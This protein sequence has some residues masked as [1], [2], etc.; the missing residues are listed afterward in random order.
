MRQGP[1]DRFPGRVGPPSIS[2]RNGR[3]GHAWLPP[4][5]PLGRVTCCCLKAIGLLGCVAV[6]L[7]AKVT[8]TGDTYLEEWLLPWGGMGNFLQEPSTFQCFDLEPS[9]G[10]VDVLGQPM[11]TAHYCVIRNLCTTS[12]GQ[13]VLFSVPPPDGRRGDAPTPTPSAGAAAGGDGWRVVPAEWSAGGPR[14]QTFEFPR[15]P[16]LQQRFTTVETAAGPNA[17]RYWRQA[18]YGRQMV[19]SG[20]AAVLRQSYC[21]HHVRHSQEPLPTLLAA[22]MDL[23]ENGTRRRRLGLADGDLK[24]QTSTSLPAAHVHL[25]YAPDGISDYVRFVAAAAAMPLVS[26]NGTSLSVRAPST[27]LLPRVTAGSVA[28]FATAVVPGSSY[29]LFPTAAIADHYRSN[30]VAHLRQGRPLVGA[31][32]QGQR[33]VLLFP[34]ETLPK[35]TAAAGTIISPSRVVLLSKRRN[36]RIVSDWPRFVQMV[37]ELVKPFQATVVEVDFSLLSVREQASAVQRADIFVALHGADLT[38]LMFLRPGTVVAELN[39]IFF[40]E[41]GYY[42]MAARLGLHYLSWTCTAPS[43]AFG[44]S[45]SEWDRIIASK[46]P[47]FSYHEATREIAY[48]GMSPFV[49][50]PIGYPGHCH[51]CDKM[52]SSPL[53]KEFYSR[54]R[55]SAVAV[56]P[57]HRAEFETLLRLAAVKLGWV[58]PPSTVTPTATSTS[59][60]TPTPTSTPTTTRVTSTRTAPRSA[61]TS[62]VRCYDMLPSLGFVDVLGQSMGTAHYCVITNLCTAADE[63]ILFDDETARADRRYEFPRQPLLQRRFTRFENTHQGLSRFARAA[64][65]GEVR[66]RSDGLAVVLRQS[67]CCA[68]VRHTQEPLPTLLA[69]LMDL[70]GNATRRV[71]LGWPRDVAA[72]P[73]VTRVH[74][75]NSGT[76]N[77]Y[78]RFVATAAASWRAAGSDDDGAFVG[79]GGNVTSHR[80][81]R[82]HGRPPTLSVTMGEDRCFELA[83]IPGA[84]YHLFPSSEMAFRYRDRMYEYAAFEDALLER[85]MGRTRSGGGAVVARPGATLD[86]AGRGAGGGKG[87]RP[88]PTAGDAPETASASGKNTKTS[89]DVMP[90]LIDRR[91]TD[92]ATRVILFSTRSSKRRV[93]NQPAFLTMLRQLAKGWGAS[94]HVVDFSNLSPTQQIAKVRGADVFMALHGADLTNLMFLRPGT[95][96]AELNP[97][98]FF[99]SGYYEMAARLGL[100]YLAWTCT[101]P[102]CAFGGDRNVWQGVIGIKAPLFTYVAANRSMTYPGQPHFVWPVLGY[103]GHCPGCDK[104]AGSS[105]LSSSFYNQ[106]RDSDVNTKRHREEFR[107]LLRLAAARLNWGPERTVFSGN[108]SI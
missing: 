37:A 13:F 69:A 5:V 47:T 16:L 82:G 6:L 8:F 85:N 95:V 104:M 66:H 45:R 56:V 75:A 11:S 99:E 57:H 14:P 71:E 7:L 15:Q 35:E 23:V 94:V 72:R 42:E 108:T 60:A 68:H 84:S 101:A 105:P 87:T 17:R 70:D 100:H 30:L 33:P 97:I 62:I 83:I 65:K 32:P 89:T 2:S 51:G 91:D 59:T 67:Y 50:P 96:V 76:L 64:A 53:S 22:M 18:Y 41:S 46:Y 90:D 26:P 54:M 12:T 21:C 38:N 107:D 39:P 58:P 31:G 28:C 44:G 78:V 93:A 92:A 1:R 73:L 43:C 20:L 25:A 3:S 24:G 27:R 10:S 63:F 61:M 19:A 80:W 34:P 55:D 79:A 4:R 40:F 98:F 88:V 9:L 103:P 52:S 74:M 77:S 86:Q 36:R 48:P 102:S 49:W 81:P 29:H 106:M